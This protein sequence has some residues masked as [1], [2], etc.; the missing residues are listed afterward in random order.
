MV[1]FVVFVCTLGFAIPAGKMGVDMDNR[2]ERFAPEGD[3][4]FA[5]LTKL[6]KEF[7]REDYFVLLMKGDVWSPKYLQKLEDLHQDIQNVQPPP[8]NLFYL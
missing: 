7:G 8:Q 1:L 5:M 4:S 6:Q 3:T 2:P